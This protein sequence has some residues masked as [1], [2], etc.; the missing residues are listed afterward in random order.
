MSKLRTKED[1]RKMKPTDMIE[2]IVD[3]RKFEVELKSLVLLTNVLGNSA[4]NSLLPIWVHL[5]KIFGSRNSE[6]SEYNLEELVDDVSCSFIPEETVKK[7]NE[8]ESINPTIKEL[9]IKVN[10]LR[11]SL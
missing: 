1:Y 3:G 2:V 10:S 11:E 7:L 9:K 4:R 8:I 5:D 6:K